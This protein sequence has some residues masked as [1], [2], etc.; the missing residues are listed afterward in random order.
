M[1]STDMVRSRTP[2]L[3][4][5]LVAV[6]AAALFAGVSSFVGPAQQQQRE[7]D[8]SRSFSG[9]SRPVPAPV[10]ALRAGPVT[11][12]DG[13]TKISDWRAVFLVL[14]LLAFFV[15]PSLGKA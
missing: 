2:V 4:V 6:A 3:A 5:L 13:D 8:V 15:F 9:A 1:G 12:A 10:S 14:T 7:V 11:E